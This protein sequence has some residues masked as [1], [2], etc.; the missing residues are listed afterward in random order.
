MPR[1]SRPVLRSGWPLLALVAGVICVVIAL[2]EMQASVR[3]NRLL[4]RTALR[5]YASFAA[6][7]YEEHFTETLRVAAQEILGGV[8]M[9]H[10][11]RPFPAASDLGH[12]LRWDVACA[13]H[14]PLQGP[15]PVAFVGFTL[16]ADTV[17]VAYNRAPVSTHGWLVDTPP[18]TIGAPRPPPHLTSA[19]RHWMNA[20]LTRLAREPLARWGYHVLV[21]R[22]GDSTLAFA[23]TRMPTA[24]GDTVIYAVQ[25]SEQS[26]DSL[27][28]ATLD[29]RDLLP[30]ALAAAGRN[31]DVLAAE[32]RDASGH[33]LLAAGVPPQW[34]LDASTILPASYG[35]LAIR[36]E[37][38]P[39]IADRA[40]AT[41]PRS[42]FPLLMALLTLAAVLT[43]LAVIQ[44]RRESRFAAARTAFIA[45][46]SHELRT[47]LAQ[48]RLVVDTLRLHRE[49]DAERRDADLAL[50]DREVTRLQHLIDNVLRFTRG[51]SVAPAILESVDVGAE[52]R[53]IVAEFLP[54]ARPAGVDVQV[55]VDGEPQ[56]LLAA[57][58]LRRVLLN[59]L[60]N[61]V[62]YGPPGQVITV[63]VAAAG[64]GATL[65]VADQGPGIAAD[66]MDRIWEA[67]ERGSAAAVRAVGGSGIG[68]T[69]VRET[70]ERNGGTAT[71]TNR[72][73]G[74]TVFTVTFGT[75]K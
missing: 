62:K 64:R 42:R 2:V 54:L 24:W 72:P 16:G 47:P 25:Y 75:Q 70:A 14:R 17:N 1:P 41:V 59:L 44:W 49:P 60:D 48:I 28:A 63:T 8:N 19:Q 23:L 56:A 38:Q 29:E 57:G 11:S 37:I 45:S 43:A 65:T 5:G 68:L 67:F 22:D 73:G 9:V 32:V 15:M 74:G 10:E 52:A 3:S 53:T 40:V 33:V 46:T 55:R 26:L 21:T 13:C 36:M 27:L 7:S 71:A 34:D 69:V 31:R 35:G 51:E 18:D 4:A 12:G 50:I 6:W 20:S 66:E 39:A 61:A 30:D 58:T